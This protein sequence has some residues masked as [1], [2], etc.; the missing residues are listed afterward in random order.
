MA[1][2]S[3]LRLAGIWLVLASAVTPAAA[4]TRGALLYATHCVA[5]HNEKVHWRQKKQAVDWDSLKSQVQLWQATGLLNWNQD[6][7]L[8]VARHLNDSHYHF[9]APRPF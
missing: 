9:A 5:C 7:V 8:Q 2:A 6:D 3:A 1:N 4:Q